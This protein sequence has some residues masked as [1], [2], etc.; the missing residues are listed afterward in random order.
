MAG[1]PPASVAH[2]SG[3]KGMMVT[4]P[5][6]VT[7]AEPSIPEAQEDQR[8]EQQ[9]RRAEEETCAPNAKRGDQ[10]E[11]QRTVAD[12]RRNLMSFKTEPL[13]VAEYQEREDHRGANQAIVKIAAERSALREI[14]D[15][16]VHSVAH[17]SH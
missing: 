14:N 12:E 3:K 16:C 9:F 8:A 15:E 6:K 10:P 13:L 7:I 4:V 11:D 1:N 17:F 5:R 2:A